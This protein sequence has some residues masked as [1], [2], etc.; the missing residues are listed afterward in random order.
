MTFINQNN[1]KSK[2]SF[3]SPYP[4]KIIP[5]DLTQFGKF[6]CQKI[7]SFARPKVFLLESNLKKLEL[8]Y[9]V[10]KVSSC[11]K[12]RRYGFVHTGGTLA[13]RISRRRNPKS[14][15][16][17]HRRFYQR[18]W[19]WHLLAASRIPFWWRR[20]IYATLRGPGTVYIQSLPFSRLAD[21]II[22]SAPRAGNS[23]DEGSLLGGLEV[24][25]MET[26]DFKFN[27]R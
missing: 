1:T 20:F 4:G 2:V 16:R 26:D 11:K 24:Y 9:L 27:K 6:I 21:R 15:H 17:L 22:A 18:R 12:N 25:S 5:I 23:R 3:A 14:R 8:G 13:K 19:L 10:G 7:L